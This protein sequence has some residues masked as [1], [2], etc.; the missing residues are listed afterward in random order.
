MLRNDSSHSRLFTL[1]ATLI[2]F[3]IN[4]NA[5]DDE[6]SADSSNCDENQKPASA[7]QCNCVNHEWTDCIYPITCNEADKKE[8]AECE[9]NTTTGQWENCI[10]SC[11]ENDPELLDSPYS[12]SDCICD[13]SIGKWSDCKKSCTEQPANQTDCE[14]NEM[15]GEWICATTCSQDIPEYVIPETCRCDEATKDW[16][17]DPILCDISQKDEKAKCDCIGEEWVNCIYPACDEDELPDYAQTCDCEK[18]NWVRD[19]CIYDRCKGKILLVGQ[20]CDSQT[21][22]ISYYPK[23]KLELDPVSLNIPENNATATFKLNLT[24]E[25]SSDVIITPSIT[26][27]AKDKLKITTSSILLTRSNWQEGV[28]VNLQTINNSVVDNDLIA[29]IKFTSSSTD[30]SFKNLET[31]GQVTILDDETPSIYLYCN[32]ANV[33]PS[34]NCKSGNSVGVNRGVND[35]YDNI[36]QRCFVSLGKKPTS[37]IKVIVSLNS[38]SRVKL[39]SPSSSSKTLTF[40]PNNYSTSQPVDFYFTENNT[41]SS[42]NLET[43]TVT[44]SVSSDSSNIYKAAPYRTTFTAHPLCHYYYFTYNNYAQSMK[45]PAGSFR[46]HAWGASGGPADAPYMKTSTTGFSC[47]NHGGAGAYVYGTLN[48]TATENIYVYTGQAGQPAGS[49]GNAP[50]SFNGGGNGRSGGSDRRGVGGGGGTDFCIGTTT[51]KYLDSHYPYRILV[52]GG[53]GGGIDPN[54]GCWNPSSYSNGG[55]ATYFNRSNGGRHEGNTTYNYNEHSLYYAQGGGQDC[56][57]KSDSGADLCYSERFGVGFNADSNGAS[58]DA[59]RRGG[60]GGGWFGGLAHAGKQKTVGGGAGSSYYFTGSNQGS[61]GKQNSK[62]KLTDPN[63][64]HGASTNM[65]YYYINNGYLYRGARLGNIG[66]GY[67]VIEVLNY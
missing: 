3:G 34:G 54:G 36:D 21:G 50:T 18:G 32:Y 22:T 40:T 61:Y 35:Y 4:I 55:N 62:Y 46:L 31:I 49:D 39:S 2:A 29:T 63:G 26:G 5:C 51:C 11:D 43:L 14:C 12:P 25:P 15:I 16:T 9:C 1:L 37:D 13:N 53:G 56:T 57:Y 65:P 27:D 20:I 41:T 44:A 33:Y 52:A 8:N 38:P 42:S 19:S 67:A 66:N 47:A 64:H 45:L 7:T 6:S 10:L 24:A 48:L 23:P 17:C 30:L 60:G 28:T 58:G 59:Y